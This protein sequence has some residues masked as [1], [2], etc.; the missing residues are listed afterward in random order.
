MDKDF[1]PLEHDKIMHQTFDAQYYHHEEEEDLL[2]PTFEYDEAIGE[3]HEE[4]VEDLLKLTFGYAEAN[5]LLCVFFYSLDGD[6]TH[7]D[8]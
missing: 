1:D 2:K 7:Y 5:E 8:N 3:C 6:L 4:E